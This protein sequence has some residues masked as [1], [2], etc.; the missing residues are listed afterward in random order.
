MPLSRPDFGAAG[1][2]VHSPSAHKAAVQAR[3]R[4]MPVVTRHGAIWFW[5]GDPAQAGEAE[6]PDFSVLDSDTP[7]TRG[8]TRFAANYQIVAD[9]LLDLSHVE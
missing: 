7:M 6:I 5:P 1:Q 9:N 3:V 2:Y 8:R 4:T